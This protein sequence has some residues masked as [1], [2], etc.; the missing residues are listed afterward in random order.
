MDSIEHR[1]TL[2]LDAVRDKRDDGTYG[3]SNIHKRRK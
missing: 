3:A 1:V 2:V